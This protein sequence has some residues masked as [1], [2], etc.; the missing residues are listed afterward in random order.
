MYGDKNGVTALYQD[1]NDPITLDLTKL[2][3]IYKYD[4]I[5]YI[6]I[7]VCKDSAGNALTATNGVV[8]LD[9]LGSYTIE[10]TVEDNIFY[11]KNGQTITKSVT[12]TYTV[13]LSLTVKAADIKNAV[14]NITKTALDGVYTTVNLTDYKLRI[15][16]L[17]CISITDYD[18]T[19][20]GS[21]VD[22]SSNISSAILTPDGVQVFSAVFTVTVTYT[23]GRVLTVNFSKISGS[24]PGTKTGTVNTSGGLYFITDGALN[25]K[26]TE[27]S[28]QNICTIT[29]V[30]FKGNNGS[31]VTN[32]TDVT[33]TWALGSSSGSNPCVTPD[34]LVTLADGT[35]KEIQYVTYE[36]QLLVWNFYKGEYAVVPAAIIFNHG[37]DHNTVIALR[38]SDGTV[39][40]V[41][42]LHQFFN[43]DLN[44]LVSIDAN[45]VA[46]YVGDRFVKQATD[47]YTTVTL[48]DYT[49]SEE[50]VAAYGIISAE[51]YNIL[52]EG[53]FSADFM[54]KDFPLFNYFA[55]GEDMKFDAEQMNADIAMY[56][57]YTY[58]DF[59]EYLTYEQFVAFNVQYFKIAVEKGDYT[60]EGILALID[61][62]LK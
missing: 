57:L 58:A 61:E 35:Q 36:D 48:V 5:N 11:D 27:A 60:Y 53:M 2:A 30:S 19:G 38:F 31:T 34:T 14:V 43:A 62:Y 51:H 3:T 9:A 55:V 18:N 8:T 10:F 7:A 39:V 59:A 1:G 52:V 40:K 15:N 24:S 17:D 16:F 37:Y 33:V 45:S 25:D 56:G 32:D 22:L 41:V 49:V 20:A 42:N 6:V 50:Y 44:S 46:Q 23:D 54:E 13:P 29:S 21:T 28:G 26:P 12:R 4:G 47:G